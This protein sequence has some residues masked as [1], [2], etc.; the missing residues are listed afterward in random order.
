M[1][2]S[3]V[4]EIITFLQKCL[5]ESGLNLSKIILFGSQVR[6]NTTPESDIDVIVVSED[7]RDKDIFER[8]KLT[9]DAEIATIKKFVVPLDIITLTAE[10]LESE[11]SLAAGY[12]KDGKLIYGT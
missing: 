4:I 12:A 1:A 10:E 3:K 11:T 6:G 5:I 8:A 7:F 9:K 2:K